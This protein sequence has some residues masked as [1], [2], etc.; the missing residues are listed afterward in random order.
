MGFFHRKSTKR[1]NGMKD[2]QKFTK[3]KN[4]SLKIFT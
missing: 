2:F 1:N 4:L 3:C